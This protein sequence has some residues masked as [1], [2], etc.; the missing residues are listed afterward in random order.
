MRGL[1][2]FFVV[3]DTEHARSALARRG[4]ANSAHLRLEETRGHAGH[5][6]QCGEAVKFRNRGTDGVSGNFGVVPFH[7]EEYRSVSENAEVV[8][9]VRVLPDVFRVDDQVFPKGLLE[10]GVEFIAPGRF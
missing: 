6:D 5:Y 1:V 3:V 8:S 7:R 2:E 10:A 4:N 9:V